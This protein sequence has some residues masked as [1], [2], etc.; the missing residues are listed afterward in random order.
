MM[1]ICTTAMVVP[2]VSITG[3]SSDKVLEIIKCSSAKYKNGAAIETS[4]TTIAVVQINIINAD[5]DNTLTV[6]GCSTTACLTGDLESTFILGPGETVSGYCYA[7]GDNELY[8]DYPLS[9][10]GELSFPGKT[11]SDLGTVTTADINGGTID[12]MTSL[13][14]TGDVA[15]GDAATDGVTVTGAIQGANALLFDGATDDTNVIT[16]AVPD[17]ASSYTLTLPGAAGTLLNDG[18]SS[19]LT[20]TGTLDD[21]TVT[22]AVTANGHVTLGSDSSDDIKIMSG[23]FVLDKGTFD[24]TVAVASIA[25]SHKTATFPDKTGNVL[26]LASEA[27]AIADLSGTSYNSD[28]E[29]AIN[30]ILAALRSADI[31]AT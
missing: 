23:D 24:L 30:S 22:G 13:T 25:G 6:K 29:N 16:L 28:A 27:S 21:L 2:E 26:V 17:P 3:S 9:T 5:L 11:I 18:G 20:T 14:A 1:L 12:G 19:T 15:L 4:G 10:S 8:F 7:G 31:I